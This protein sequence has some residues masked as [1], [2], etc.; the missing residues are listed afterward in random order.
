[1]HSDNMAVGNIGHGFV[2]GRSAGEGETNGRGVA[3]VRDANYHPDGSQVFFPKSGR[4]FV[5]LLAPASVGDDVN[6]ED[7]VAIWFDGSSGFHVAP[8]VWHQSPFT[9]DDVAVFNTK[10]SSVFASVSV[11]TV[12]EFGKYLKVPLVPSD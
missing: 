5:L 2:T 10:Q 11:D 12:K 9:T 4:P 7:F 3:Y 6:P 8:N 1:V